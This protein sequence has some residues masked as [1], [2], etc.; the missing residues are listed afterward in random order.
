ML[1]RAFSRLVEFTLILLGAATLLPFEDS[2]VTDLVI[3]ACWDLVAFV[4]LLIRWIRVR[5]SR[6][7]DQQ[8][9]RGLLGRRAGY[10]FTLLASITGISAGLNIALFPVLTGDL[11][12]LDLLAKVEGV[13]AVIMAWLILHFGYA[14]RYAHLYYDRLPERAMVFPGT[15]SPT[16]LEFTYFAFTLGTSFAVSD[17]E[18]RDSAVR[19]RVLTHSVLSFFYNTAILGIA[20]GVVSGK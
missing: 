12:Q 20:V 11:A 3:I 1:R 6:P 7:G 17:V 8:W 2:A 13:P 15:E 14:E 9:L 16:F 4:Y 5:R 19:M 10:V 18:V